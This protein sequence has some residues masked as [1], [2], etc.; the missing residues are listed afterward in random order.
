MSTQIDY[1]EYLEEKYK[2]AIEKMVEE[3][4]ESLKMWSAAVLRLCNTASRFI[5]DPK[6]IECERALIVFAVKGLIKITFC[7]DGN[8]KVSKA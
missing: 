5:E 4:N 1:V 3:L 6:M 8:L 2:Q 7:E